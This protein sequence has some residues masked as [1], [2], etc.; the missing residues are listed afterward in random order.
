[1]L[2]ELDPAFNAAPL[3]YDMTAFAPKYWLINGKGYPE[4]DEI[5]TAA[6]NTVLLRY[7]NAGLVHHSM[8][9][10]G[11]HQTIVATDGQP[12]TNQS[13]VVAQTVPAGG[14][15]DTIVAMPASRP[16]G[17]QY[18]AVRGCDARGQQRAPRPAASSTSAGC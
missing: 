10:L 1:M 14:T 2:S 7:V 11:L 6:G 16:G 17:T 9:L 8:G 15:L 18:A 12:A 5:A 4:T 13:T 3:T